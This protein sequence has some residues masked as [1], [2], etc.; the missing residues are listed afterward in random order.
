C[1][2]GIAWGGSWDGLP[3]L[4]ALNAPAPR[5][6][7][8]AMLGQLSAPSGFLVAG[9]LFLFLYT[10]LTPADFMDWGWRFPFFVALAINVVA[11][12]A[13]LRL[14]MDNDFSR[15]LEDRE[16]TPI[17]TLDMIRTQGR[18][19]ATG[20]FA[21]LASYALFHLVTLFPLSW[22]MLQNPQSVAHV[23]SIQLVGA[24]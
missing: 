1:L 6:G 24:V 15:L 10:R 2:Q 14:V 11:L 18:H 7:W 20:A 3:S 22:L 9:S 8:D 17:G 13:R 23:L 19:I 12:F 4:L 5:R 16:L 21:A